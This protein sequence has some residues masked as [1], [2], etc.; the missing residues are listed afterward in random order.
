[1]L[2]I[3]GIGLLGLFALMV[4]PPGV[5]DEVNPM[6]YG[7][8]NVILADPVGNVLMAQTVHNLLT[9][10]GET[11]VI[12][13]VFDTST[14]ALTGQARVNAI[15]IYEA[16]DSAF[17][18]SATDG[19]SNALSGTGSSCHAAGSGLI[20]NTN[21]VATTE[22]EIFVAGTDFDAGGTISGILICGGNGAVATF[23]ACSTPGGSVALAAVNINNVTVT[24]TDTIT[25]TYTF[26]ITTPSS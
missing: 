22:G 16:L 25:I 20:G 3:V 24:G 9:D 26:D 1:M 5:A 17:S 11:F 6:F 14:A 23:A 4:I 18:E 12:N 8:A 7:T 21:Q 13:Q 10:Q 2:K 19:L 15:C